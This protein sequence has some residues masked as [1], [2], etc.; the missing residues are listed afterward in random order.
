MK[1]LL[2]TLALVLAA[3]FA[4][5]NGIDDGCP[6]LTYKTAPVAKADQYICHKQYAV[7]YS[8]AAKNPAYTT[9]Y[10]SADHVGAVAAGP[11]GAT[12]LTTTSGAAPDGSGQAVTPIGHVE[13][14]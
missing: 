9:E 4:S 14:R 12:H 1:K 5:A 11:G 2:I 8:Y 6:T 3:P 10:L 13:R 7:A